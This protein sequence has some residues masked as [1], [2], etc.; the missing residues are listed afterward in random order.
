[1][2]FPVPETDVLNSGTPNKQFLPAEV[3]PHV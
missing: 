2:I 1:M 3:G